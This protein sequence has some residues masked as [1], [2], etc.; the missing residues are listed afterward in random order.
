MLASSVG[1]LKA[2]G[3]ELLARQY[4]SRFGTTR[5]E[6]PQDVRETEAEVDRWFRKLASLSQ[7]KQYVAPNSVDPNCA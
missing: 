3:R 4:Q 7:A 2:L 5:F 1:S 6:R